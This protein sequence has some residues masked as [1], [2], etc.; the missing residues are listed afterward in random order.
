MSTDDPPS[1]LTL[2]LI[3]SSCLGI[4]GIDRFYLGQIWTGIAKLL[5]FGGAGIWALVDYY[6]VLFNAASES[7]T[8]TLGVR[9]WSDTD[10]KLAQKVAIAMTFVT[11][12]TMSLIVLKCQ[13]CSAIKYKVD[14]KK[15]IDKKKDTDHDTGHP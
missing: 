14:K 9:E 10:L 8:G 2:L 1:K 12:I 4:L 11:V 15:S 13:E 3:Q 7:R 5:T 6:R